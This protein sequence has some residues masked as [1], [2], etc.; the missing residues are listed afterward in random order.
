MVIHQKWEK[1]EIA[2]VGQ[3]GDI[4]RTVDDMKKGGIGSFLL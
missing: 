1:R 2:K 4:T 3:D